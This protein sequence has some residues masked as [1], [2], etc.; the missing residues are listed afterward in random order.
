LI[1]DDHVWD[2]QIE[3]DVR[4]GKIDNLAQE[5]LAAHRAEK[6]KKL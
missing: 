3:E 2:S 1:F 6:C 5:A 4:E